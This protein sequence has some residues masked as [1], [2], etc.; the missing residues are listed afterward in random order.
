MIIRFWMI[1]V[2]TIEMKWLLQMFTGF[3]IERN[4]V[5]R[6]D[7]WRAYISG[8]LVVTGCDNP[9]DLLDL[10]AGAKM[11]PGN[12]DY[13]LHTADHKSPRC[14]SVVSEKQVR[15]KKCTRYRATIKKKLNLVQSTSERP[16]STYGNSYSPVTDPLSQVQRLGKPGSPNIL[17]WFEI[18]WL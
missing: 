2:W 17:Q 5:F 7:R 10:V 11:C 3:N 15:C 8:K 4:I 13:A 18:L 16:A 6:H 12:T 1:I 9:S 14:L